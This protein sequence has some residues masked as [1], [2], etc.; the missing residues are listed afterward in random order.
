MKTAK[1]FRYGAT[2]MLA[3][4]WMATSASAQLV[5][6]ASKPTVEGNKAVVKI[7]LENKLTNAVESARASIF[8]LDEKKAT[9]GQATQW[10][11]GG[12]KAKSVLPAGGTNIFYFVITSQKPYAGTHLTSKLTFNRVLLSGGEVVDLKKNVEVHE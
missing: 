1:S 12:S 8:L 2:L 4:A 9:V 6:T 3:T 10:V 11:I 5:V 7:T